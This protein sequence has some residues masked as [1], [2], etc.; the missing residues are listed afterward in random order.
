M[1][2]N[3]STLILV[4][5]SSACLE[6]RVADV[7]EPTEQSGLDPEC[8]YEEFD[9]IVRAIWP[10]SPSSPVVE[11]NLS[12]GDLSDV[13]LLD[14]DVHACKQ[15]ILYGGAFFFKDATPFEGDPHAEP[16]DAEG[17]IIGETREGRGWLT[18]FHDFQLIVN[19]E[20]V[21]QLDEM[22]EM[23]VS[24]IA[25]SPQFRDLE[26]VM[27]PGDMLK[28][29]FT[30]SIHPDNPPKSVQRFGLT[31]SPTVRWLEEREPGPGYSPWGMQ[32]TYPQQ[33][34]IVP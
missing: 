19:G 13:P 9:Y 16:R 32:I 27:E 3:L 21:A 15:V 28:F 11:I 6:H 7:D 4:M 23:T 5:A 30:A 2:H 20:L 25:G 29:G 22:H 14:Y 31:Y 1:R 24:D 10:T 18:R 17:I 8:V 33:I 34:F 12:S 26:Y